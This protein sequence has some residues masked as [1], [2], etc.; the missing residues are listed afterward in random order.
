MCRYDSEEERDVEWRHIAAT[1][2]HPATATKDERV[3]AMESLRT[4][5]ALALTDLRMAVRRRVGTRG[6]GLQRPASRVLLLVP[7][8]QVAD[9]FLS[10]KQVRCAARRVLLWSRQASPRQCPW[11]AIK[12]V[13]Y[14]PAESVVAGMRVEAATAVYSRIIDLDHCRQFIH[15]LPAS[16]RLTL[17]HRLGWLNV[18]VG[19]CNPCHPHGR[20]PPSCAHAPHVLCSLSPIMPDHTFALDFAYADHRRV[21]FLLMSLDNQEPGDSWLRAR[22][23]GGG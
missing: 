1:P 16:G 6:Q 20:R 23:V 19:G 21:A 22:W 11:Q 2:D 5:V 7:P 18:Y 14:F 15:A 9:V 13:R 10:V 3:A 12:I 17:A 4:R 8:L